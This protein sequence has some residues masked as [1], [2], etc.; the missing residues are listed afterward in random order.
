MSE[1]AILVHDDADLFREAVGYTAARTGFLPRLIEKD[2]FCTLLL[3]HLATADPRLVFKGGTCLS[4]V[5]CDFFRLS[6]DLD[7]ALSLATTA[8]RKQRRS[9]VERCKF[10]V[11]K[12]RASLPVFRVTV[13]LGGANESAQYNAELVY[14][15]LVAGTDEAVKI[16]ISLREPVVL[17]VVSSPARTMLLNPIS[18]DPMVPPIDVRCL[19]YAEAMAEKFRAA[20]TRPEVA[21]RDFFD[22]DHGLTCRRLDATAPDFVEL[23]RQKVSI[24]GCVTFGAGPERLAVLRKQLDTRLRPVLREQEFKQ[25]DLDRAFEAVAEIA[26][27]LGRI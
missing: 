24:P 16:E 22:L 27:A 4:K 18:S 5:H 20:L 25:F 12:V 9:E 14:R 11:G 23:V 3:A 8:T 2:Y 1:D 13:P 21:I 17:P 7:F 15:S 26:Q 6:E 10:S 19:A